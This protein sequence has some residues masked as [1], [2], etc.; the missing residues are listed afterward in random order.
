M[1]RRDFSGSRARAY[2]TIFLMAALLT[3]SPG[4]DSSR[5]A[6]NR[7]SSL[8][9]YESYDE[10]LKT[11]P[12]SRFVQQA[13]KCLQS[14][15][16]TRWRSIVQHFEHSKCST[17][18]PSLTKHPVVPIPLDERLLSIQESAFPGL[19][20]DR[21]RVSVVYLLYSY[22]RGPS[23][24]PWASSSHTIPPSMN[25][26]STE[27]IRIT[28]DPFVVSGNAVYNMS[29]LEAAGGDGCSSYKCIVT[30]AMK[31]LSLPGGN[32]IIATCVGYATGVDLSVNTWEDKEVQLIVDVLKSSPNWAD[33]LQAAFTLA[34][35]RETKA[36][37]ILLDYLRDQ[38]S[39]LS[40]VAVEA[41]G[42]IGDPR[43]IVPLAQVLLNGWGSLR[44]QTWEADDEI[45]LSKFLVDGSWWLG[46]RRV[47][48]EQPIGVILALRNIDG[49]WWLDDITA[50]KIRSSRPEVR[51]RKERAIVSAWN[52]LLPQF[53][54]YLKDSRPFVRQQSAATLGAL[55]EKGAV[56]ALRATLDDQNDFVAC[57]ACKA[58]GFIAERGSMEALIRV[59]VD[60]TRA[61]QVR[62]AAAEALGLIRDP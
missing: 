62:A 49:S 1:I 3:G 7:A 32:D 53:L 18:T 51:W 11:H 56:E 58:L 40:K 13:D 52:A 14:H 37:P 23:L 48:D 26:R 34:N 29:K 46:D 33:R 28:V 10:F 45:Q 17:D 38:A 61:Q 24:I 31:N 21:G 27:G 25:L 44:E 54:S 36:V 2:L 15:A 35:R 50:R 8:D 60:A 9:T 6:W 5:S 4:C 47:R 22:A 16:V 20:V 19:L 57:E 39:P 41:L 55:R 42:I 43:G 30:D 59:S 12:N